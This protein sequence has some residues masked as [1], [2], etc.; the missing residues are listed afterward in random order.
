M[1]IT[2]D[3]KGRNPKRGENLPFLLFFPMKTINFVS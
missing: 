3:V 2:I 1:F